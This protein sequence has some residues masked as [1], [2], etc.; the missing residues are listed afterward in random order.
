MLHT[1]SQNVD[2]KC[3]VPQNDAGRMEVRKKKT[4]RR[5]E[6]EWIFSHKMKANIIE[7]VR[8]PFIKIVLLLVHERN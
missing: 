4:Q 2:D 1:Y 7:R 3:R 6:R 5:C 8:D